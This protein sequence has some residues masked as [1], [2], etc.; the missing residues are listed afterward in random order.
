MIQSQ[1]TN[2]PAS[3]SFTAKQALEH[4]LQSADLD[5][6]L[7]IGYDKD[8]VLFVRSSKLTRAEAVFLLEKGKL[9]ALNVGHNNELN[10]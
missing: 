10:T 3:T 1:V 2:L 7:I 9:W 5:D 8:G 4:A 6:V